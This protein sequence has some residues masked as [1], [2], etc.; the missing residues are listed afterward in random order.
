M[1]DTLRFQINNTHDI[2][3]QIRA[4]S[5]E[6]RYVNNEK[7]EMVFR[8]LNKDIPIGSFDYH[9]N[10]FIGDINKIYLEFSAPKIYW[11]HNAWLL[12]PN[13]LERVLQKIDFNL[14][15]TFN[16]HFPS[17]K[18][19]EL[20]RLDLC[21]AWK[22]ENNQKAN[23]ALDTLRVLNYPRKNTLTYDTSVTF[24]GSAYTVKFYLKDD[25]Y[26][27][28]DYKR[29]SKKNREYADFLLAD[30]NGLLR[31]E[32][33]LRKKQLQTIFHKK[34][35]KYTDICNQELLIKIMN[36]Y[37]NKLLKYSTTAVVEFKD[38]VNQIKSMY[39]L[40]KARRLIEF[41]QM[42]YSDNPAKRQE[43]INNYS[44][45]TIWRYKTELAKARV[46][47]LNQNTKIDFNFDIPSPL[48]I[49]SSSD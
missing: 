45:T 9:V 11:G 30:S 36:D 39:P 13:L 31:F 33:T 1:I 18:E 29:L 20:Q 35:I 41:H 48:V 24:R 46:G 7:G 40:N 26:L 12:Y 23:S 15:L 4:L 10:L 21:Y 22:F 19:W 32:I 3:E 2:Y 14:W 47:I 5:F 17:Y 8:F 25:E 34:S 49:N 43:I 28:H 16:I 6:K 37:L 42:Y 27:K 38:I 44:R